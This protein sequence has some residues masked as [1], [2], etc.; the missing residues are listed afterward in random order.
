MQ[1]A[2]TES[3]TNKKP[4]KTNTKT[5]AVKQKPPNKHA[6]GQMA[7]WEILQTCKELI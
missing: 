6:Q 2:M 5:E 4:R 1:P 3:K 7:L